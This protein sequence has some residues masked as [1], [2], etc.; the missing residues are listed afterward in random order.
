MAPTPTNSLPLVARFLDNR[1][2]DNR[3]LSQAEETPTRA[4]GQALFINKIESFQV[5]LVF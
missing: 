5:I 4:A 3:A 1:V 2:Q